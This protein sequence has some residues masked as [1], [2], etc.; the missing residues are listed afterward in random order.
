MGPSSTATQDSL[1]NIA[2]TDKMGTENVEVPSFQG[3]AHTVCEVEVDEIFDKANISIN[4]DVQ[5]VNTH[6]EVFGCGEELQKQLDNECNQLLAKLNAAIPDSS[7]TPSESSFT[8]PALESEAIGAVDKSKDEHQAF[9]NDYH[10]EIES[11]IG[12]CKGAD[13]RNYEEEDEELEHQLNLECE[14]LRAKIARAISGPEI[15][16][17]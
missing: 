17:T 14:M 12:M 1:Q 7:T 4:R 5:D 10:D 11:E 3:I 13:N 16:K 2:I 9:V 8:T 15:E 6:A